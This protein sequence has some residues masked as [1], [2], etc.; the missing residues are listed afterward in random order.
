MFRPAAL[1]ILTSTKHMG[2]TVQT[3]AAVRQLLD[4][5]VPQ[6][7]IAF[8]RAFDDDPVGQWMFPVASHRKAKLEHLFALYIREVSLADDWGLASA[9]LEGAALWKPP[10][11]WKVPPLV[12]VRMLP[13][14]TRLI[15]RRLPT[16]MRGLVA[17]EKAHPHEPHAYLPFVGVAPEHQNKGIGSSLLRP[18]LDRCNREG[19]GAYLEASTDANIRLYERL[20]FEVT[21]E[22]ELAGGLTVWQMWK[23]ATDGKA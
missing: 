23:S 15:G 3:S 14:Y 21:A 2:G 12:S 10:G 20:G 8:A 7:A 9:G 11:S 13:T 6:I 22:L 1:R 17:L 18:V 5:D 16:V 19:I 4:E